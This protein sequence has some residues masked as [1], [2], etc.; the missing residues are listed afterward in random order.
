MCRNDNSSQPIWL[1]DVRCANDFQDCIANCISTCPTE[2]NTSD[3]CEDTSITCGE[4]HYY[5]RDIC[6]P[7][8]L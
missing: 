6:T 1:R 4:L 8:L 7:M 2:G 3:S 5:V